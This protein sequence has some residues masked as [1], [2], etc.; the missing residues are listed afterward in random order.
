MTDYSQIKALNWST[1]KNLAV[2]PLLYRWRLDHPEPRKQAY[3]M[4]NAIHTAILEPGKFDARFAVY[5]GRR[6][7]KAWDDWQA[8]H[9]GV[10]SLK[11]DE[12]ARVQCVVRA[13]REHRAIRPLL[14][15][16]LFEEPIQWTDRETGLACKGRVDYLKPTTL[17]DLKSARAIG[18]RDFGRACAQYLYHGQLA[19]YWEGAIMGGRLPPDAE[20]PSIVVVESDEPFDCGV[21]RM[22]PEDMAKGVALYRQLLNR[23]VECTAADHWPGQLPDAERLDIPEWAPGAETETTEMEF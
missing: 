5:D 4:G 20:L 15:G 17:V 23:F 7:G 11:P 19:F 3:V 10:E 8:E 12:M 13:C 14:G 21:Y 6:A 18:K 22:T 2:S 1:L 9:P 16:G